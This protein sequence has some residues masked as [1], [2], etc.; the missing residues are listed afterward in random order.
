MV[1]SN[2]SDKPKAKQKYFVSKDIQERDIQL[3]PILLLLLA[4]PLRRGYDFLCSTV[5]HHKLKRLLM[6]LCVEGSDQRDNDNDFI[7][8]QVFLRSY[9]SAPRP[10]PSPSPVT[11]LSLFL[12]L[13]LCVAGPAY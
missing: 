7:Q 4:I 1:I 12:S 2:K 3:L 11:K 8:D 9:D 13:S 5:N 10:S 6:V